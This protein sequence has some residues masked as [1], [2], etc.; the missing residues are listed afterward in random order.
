MKEAA[1]NQGL[2][3]LILGLKWIQD[4]IGKFGGDRNRVTIFG[5]SA[6]GGAVSLLTLSPMAKGQSRIHV[7]ILEM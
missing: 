2:K 7:F 3:D 1:G 6:G 5:E 4:N